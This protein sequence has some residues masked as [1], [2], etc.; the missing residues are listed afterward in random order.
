[1][2]PGAG[3]YTYYITKRGRPGWFPKAAPV[4]GLYFLVHPALQAL[5]LSCAQ[6]P[7]HKAVVL[8][9]KPAAPLCQQVFHRQGGRFEGGDKLDLLHPLLPQGLQRLPGAVEPG[10]QI[11]GRHPQGAAL[12]LGVK[13][14]EVALQ[15]FHME[16]GALSAG[17][18][19]GRTGSHHSRFM[20]VPSCS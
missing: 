19:W 16:A 14:Q 9:G 15:R 3:P 8:Q 10:G 11:V 20:V 4:R 17:V 1:M 6:L 5:G 7:A 18:G 12:L 13:G 2:S